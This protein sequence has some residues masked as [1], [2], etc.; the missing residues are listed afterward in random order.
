MCAGTRRLR[1]LRTSRDAKA[2]SPASLTTLL[3]AA[4]FG[5]TSH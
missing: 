4:G 2:M 3:P 5:E 1:F